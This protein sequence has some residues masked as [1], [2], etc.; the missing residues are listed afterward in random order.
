MSGAATN[1]YSASVFF[2]RSFALDCIFQ[3]TVWQNLNRYMV[4]EVFGQC[5]IFVCWPLTRLHLLL[6]LG[7]AK[8]LHPFLL[9]H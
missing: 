3:T 8:L 7:K 2:I 5:L 9:Q 6:L 4:F 1:F